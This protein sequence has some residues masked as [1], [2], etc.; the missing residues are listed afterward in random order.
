M[1]E[2]EGPDLHFAL[3]ND[4]NANEEADYVASV[5]ILVQLVML[6]F[7][8]VIGHILRRNKI[9]VVHEAGAALL[10]GVSFSLGP[11]F[12][13]CQHFQA[14]LTILAADPPSNLSAT[15][16]YLWLLSIFVKLQ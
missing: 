7:T 10:T 2:F 16:L 6:G 9:M 14:Y 8:F 4:P 1:T 3:Q 13:F 5:S 11:Y 12:V 15:H